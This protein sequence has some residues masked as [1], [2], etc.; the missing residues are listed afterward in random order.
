MYISG[1]G[2]SKKTLGLFLNLRHVYT[3]YFYPL[4]NL[5][6]MLTPPTRIA[7]VLYGRPHCENDVSFAKAAVYCSMHGLILGEKI[8]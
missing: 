8:V 5:K 7:D 6:E 1:L 4:V 3:F 2:S